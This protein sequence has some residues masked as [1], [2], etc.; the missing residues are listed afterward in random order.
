MCSLVMTATESRGPA[1]VS[2]TGLDLLRQAAEKLH[3]ETAERPAGSVAGAELV[4]LHRLSESLR[5]V[6]SG[7]LR[8]FERSG[9]YAAQGGALS[10]A[11]WLRHE[12]HLSPNAA[13][14]QV[15]VARTLPEL[16]ETAAAFA[17]GEISFQHAALLTRSAEEVGLQVV[18][19]AQPIFLAAARQLDPQRLRLATRH[20]RYCLD[21]QGAEA[22]AEQLCE[23]RGLHLSQSLE[24]VFYKGG[25]R[26]EAGF[27]PAAGWGESPPAGRAPEPE[28][29]SL[30]Q[31]AL[32]ACSGLPAADDERSP[33]QRR[34]DALVELSRQQLDSGRLPQVGGQRP[35][36]SLRVELTALRPG[37]PAE[38]LENGQ[39]LGMEAVRRTACD[40]VLE[41]LLVG[42]AGEPL[43]AGRSRRVVSGALRRALAARDGG[44]R[45][46]GCDR[47]PGWTDAH[48]LVHWA[49]GGETALSN[50]ALL[51][52]PHHRRAH[53][54]GW[55]L[56]PDGA[57][58][59]RAIPP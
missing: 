33:A 56:L 57:G 58:G 50:T 1:E 2:A 25:G 9:A 15:R 17:A 24:G 35:H 42:A 28:G 39:P 51:C 23:R 3:R 44:C 48:H 30:L 14:E 16:P 34:A 22:A 12:C 7:Q 41:V 26:R 55:R 43:G 59:L 5:A 8:D 37:D 36:L 20:L 11:A 27:I 53:E 38:E 40:A 10:A 19:E 47:P 46:P 13:A 18:Q 29:G 49:E 52:R 45:F 32:E 31:K 21:R 54:E 4:E 6:F